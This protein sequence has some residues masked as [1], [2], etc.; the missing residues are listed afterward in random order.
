MLWTSGGLT[1]VHATIGVIAQRK[2]EM[3]ASWMQSTT[4]RYYLCLVLD[5]CGS[6]GAV[7]VLPVVVLVQLSAQ[8]SLILFALSN[9]KTEDRH[10][11]ITVS[12]LYHHISTFISTSLHTL[13][14]PTPRIDLS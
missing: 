11:I 14:T 6:K 9:D 12:S 8:F 2:D 10:C 1:L 3:H 7:V 13:I 5:L 4:M